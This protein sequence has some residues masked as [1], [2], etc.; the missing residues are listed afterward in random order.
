MTINT[1]S[2]TTDNGKTT[3]KATITDEMGKLL[4]TS[5]KVTIKVNNKTVLTGVNSTNGNVDVS[6][7]T[8]L[9]PGMYELLIISGEN[10]LYKSGKMTTVLKI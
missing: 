4:V 9:K 5:T 8:S 7:I 10:A 1:D 6:F 3:V 2:I